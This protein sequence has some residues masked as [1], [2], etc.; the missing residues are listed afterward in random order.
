M[1]LLAE[2]KRK[3]KYGLDPQN[4][5]WSNDTNKFGQRLMEKMGWEKGKGLGANENGMTE[6][7]KASY[8]WDQS[9]LGASPQ[10]ADAWVAHQ[11]DYNDLLK[12]LNSGNQDDTLKDKNETSDAKDGCKRYYGRF[13]RGRV[14]KLRTTED[15]DCIF[16]RRKSASAPATPSNQSAANSGDENDS[17]SEGGTEKS[18]GLTTVTSTTSVQDY[19]A[20]K[21]KEMKARQLKASA[22]EGRAASTEKSDKSEQHQTEPAVYGMVKFSYGDSDKEDSNKKDCEADGKKNENLSRGWYQS[23]NCDPK[24]KKDAKKQEEENCSKSKL[25]IKKEDK[26]ARNGDDT[27]KRPRDRGN[28]KDVTLEETG[29]KEATRED[30]EQRTS[31]KKKKKRKAEQDE[32]VREKFSKKAKLV[33]DAQSAKSGKIEEREA[34]VVCD[35][36]SGIHDIENYEESEKI[37]KKKK[38]RKAEKE[39]EDSAETDRKSK[40]VSEVGKKGESVVDVKEN[41]DGSSKTKSKKK[42]E[43][44]FLESVNSTKYATNDITD[45]SAAEPSSQVLDSK[46]PEKKKKHKT[47]RKKYKSKRPPKDEDVELDGSSGHTKMNK[48]TK[49]KHSEESSTKRGKKKEPVVKPK[50]SIFPGSNIEDV[51]GYGEIKTKTLSNDELQA[52]VTEAKKDK[53]KKTKKLVIAV[54][55]RLRN[56]ARLQGGMVGHTEKKFDF[57]IAAEIN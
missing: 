5:N 7:I 40:S 30:L 45:T 9:G 49:T 56:M 27:P 2:G 23:W 36:N 6:H 22:L 37:S 11:D 26:R 54:D 50:K 25:K 16:G 55:E 20:N 46:L 57:D 43:K 32:E 33:N 10:S 28:A 39:F 38:K 14:Q 13:A 52:N 53:K 21:M 42:K 1:A 47:K 44:S 34:K 17:E 3:V 4:T 35:K 15:L 24:E 12:M 29:N 8:K 41:V 19:F 51:D 31:S 48:A 18:H